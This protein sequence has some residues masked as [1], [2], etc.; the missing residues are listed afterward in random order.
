MKQSIKQEFYTLASIANNIF[1]RKIHR[2][3][4]IAFRMKYN[5]RILP[6]TTEFVVLIFH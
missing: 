6:A 3:R 1:C 4:K 5:A 2:L